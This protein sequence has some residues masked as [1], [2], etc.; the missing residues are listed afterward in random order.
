MKYLL[1]FLA[2]LLVGVAILFV[3][4]NQNETPSLPNASDQLL[5]E[6]L[7]EWTSLPDTSQST[8]AFFFHLNGARIGTV[9][10][11]VR[12]QRVRI[13]SLYHVPEGVVIAQWI[14]ESKWG[15]ADL[16]ANNYLGHT[17]AATKKFYS[18]RDLC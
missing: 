14:L 1:V 17:F 3:L 2:G 8:T 6:I 10:D 18:P 16:G 15:L 9:P 7:S 11:T 13:D 12:V 4:Y 5:N